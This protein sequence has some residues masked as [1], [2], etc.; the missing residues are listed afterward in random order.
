MADTQTEETL[1]ALE[2]EREGYVAAGKDDRAKQV[3]DEIKRLKGGKARA[4]AKKR[5]RQDGRLNQ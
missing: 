4:S 3:D 1:A 5:H 2:H